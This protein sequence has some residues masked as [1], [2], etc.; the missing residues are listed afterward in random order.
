MLKKGEVTIGGWVQIGHPEIA[1]IMA[2]I[3]FDWIVF[4][5]EHAP[6]SFE[7]TQNLIQAIKCTESIPLVRVAWNDPVL[8]KCALD[9][10][11]YG[12]IIPW[13]TNKDEALKAVRSCKYPLK[14][15]RG[16]G[17]RRAS[18]YGIKL[19]EYIA[20]A[21]QE[22]MT[23]IQIETIEA[24]YNIKEILSINGIDAFFI[25]P[26][27]LAASMGL[28]GQPNHPKVQEIIQKILNE[29]KKAGVPA[30]IAAFTPEAAIEY[31]KKGFQFIQLMTDT[32]IFVQACIKILR[33]VREGIKFSNI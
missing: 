5:M 11:A 1:E 16:F 13:V 30:G 19:N 22:I 33:K 7:T 29:G 24:F 21:D 20:T 17:P 14:G 3:G 4:D 31:A 18:K 25:G 9:I 32:D 12:V 28:I 26:N 15:I 23:V 27:D 10:G 8:V 2:E 6:L